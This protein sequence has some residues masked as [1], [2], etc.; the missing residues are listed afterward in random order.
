MGKMLV[1]FTIV[2]SFVLAILPN[3]LWLL[4]YL[5]AKCFGTSVRYAPFGWTAFGLVFLFLFLMG[6]GY[7]IG[8]WR[9]NED[10]FT[11]RNKDIPAAFDKLKIVHIS[12]LHLSTFDKHPEFLFEIVGRVNAQTPDIICFT[13]DLV[14]I[15]VSEAQRYTEVLRGFKA[16]YGIYSVLGNHDFMIYG[17]RQDENERLEEVERL[18]S[19]ERDTLGWRL[20]RNSSERITADDGS[21]ITIIGVDNK[22]C[23]K[24]FFHSTDTGDLDKALEGTEGFRILLSHDPSHWDA[25]VVPNTDIPL[26]LS[27][28]TH[29]A[30]LK[31]FGWTP[32]SLFFQRTDG[33]YSLDGQTLYVNTGIGCTAPLRLGVPVE[34]TTIVLSSN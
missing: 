29:A 20:L 25:E 3:M 8:R 31:L 11:Y 33:E 28:H 26:T 27:G 22:S 24:Q 16:R 14:T 18:S 23:R 13:G 15:G 1:F 6:Y 2:C 4:C 12:D 17:W 10:G 7:Y 9:I 21:Y 5:V 32:A 34:I 19:Y 30:Q